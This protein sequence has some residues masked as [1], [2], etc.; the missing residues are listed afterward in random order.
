MECMGCK[1]NTVRPEGQGV[2]AQSNA[3]KEWGMFKS[4]EVDGKR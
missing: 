4:L 3:M 1:V 2:F